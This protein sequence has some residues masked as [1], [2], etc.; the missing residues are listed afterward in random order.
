MNLISFTHPVSQ[1]V[2]P[3]RHNG[4]LCLFVVLLLLYSC[5]WDQM[6]REGGYT[7][8]RITYQFFYFVL[9]YAIS[10]GFEYM[11]KHFVF[12][13]NVCFKTALRQTHKLLSYIV[14]LHLMKV[15]VIRKAFA[16]GYI[17]GVTTRSLGVYIK[18]GP[19]IT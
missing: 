6:R 13:R 1:P 12:D 7:A 10:G 19:R 5:W 14:Y 17:K 18:G 2:R 3:S 9:K 11:Q 15:S 16:Q 8:R 4:L